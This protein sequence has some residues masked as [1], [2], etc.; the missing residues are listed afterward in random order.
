MPEIISSIVLNSLEPN[1]TR[2]QFKT[3][4]DMYGVKQGYIDEGHIS[5]CEETKKHYKYNSNS[6]QLT[7][8][9]RWTLLIPEAVGQLDDVL[10]YNTI[11]DL[12]DVPESDIKE[13]SVARL[14]FCLEDHQHYY[15]VYGLSG[16]VFDESG[17][18]WW[19]KLLDLADSDYVTKED[20]E[21]YGKDI[22]FDFKSDL[23]NDHPE[24][25]FGQIV[26]C[27]ED[28]MHY[29][30]AYNGDGSE[31][32]EETGYFRR[33]SGQGQYL[34]TLNPNITTTEKVGGVEIGTK[35]EDL[36][37]KSYDDIFNIILYTKISPKTIDPTASLII[38]SLDNEEHI[39][40]VGAS[41]PTAGDFT[42]RAE[43]GHWYLSSIDN[44]DWAGH[45]VSMDDPNAEFKSYIRYQYNDGEITNSLPDKIQLGENKYHVR[46][47]FEDG[48]LLHNS[49]GE[50]LP[51][52][53]WKSSTPV[54]STEPYI[55]YGT[56]PWYTW[57]GNDWKMM[58]LFKWTINAVQVETSMEAS[59]KSPQR[60]KLPRP[61]QNIYICN[62]MSS[63]KDDIN[64]YM[65]SRDGEYFVY[66]YNSGVCGHRGS[67][68]LIIE[69]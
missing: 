64:N 1:F 2:D 38:D 7:G 31:Y 61:V 25:S 44:G 6:G 39:M 3:L 45:L 24:L 4:A 37:G 19:K 11:Q 5:Y 42:I 66:E 32:L 57:E 20:L 23:L 17:S 26:F 21:E 27:K 53:Q 50:I 22:E 65:Y 68:K 69:F 47:Y 58:P 9:D 28:S 60:F 18:G 34:S 8:K 49:H 29:Y 16:E 15:N 41:A 52:M 67:V 14:A 54:D 33:L 10:I 43:R 35:L 40:C 59:C 36:V 13:I 63:I 62:G 30:Y 56:L 55:V 12:H 51:R 46:A 48:D